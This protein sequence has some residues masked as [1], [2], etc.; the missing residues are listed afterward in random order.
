MARYVRKLPESVRCYA[1]SEGMENVLEW[2]Y[3]FSGP[4]DLTQDLL[5]GG[6]CDK[7]ARTAVQVWSHIQKDQRF[8]ESGEKGG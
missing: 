2:A 8:R 5:Q 4:D 1:Q 6:I 7:D 3:C